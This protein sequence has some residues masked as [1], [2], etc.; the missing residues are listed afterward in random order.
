MRPLSPPNP[1]PR[2]ASAFRRAQT[3][4]DEPFGWHAAATGFRTPH[5][6]SVVRTESVCRRSMRPR[7]RRAPRLT[8]CSSRTQAP[9]FASLVRRCSFDGREGSAVLMRESWERGLTLCGFEVWHLGMWVAQRVY[10]CTCRGEKSLSSSEIVI[11]LP[12]LPRLPRGAHHAHTP[13]LVLHP[14]AASLPRTPAPCVGHNGDRCA[15][16]R[17][18]ASVLHSLR[19][20]TRRA[21]QP[22][23]TIPLRSLSSLGSSSLA[24]PPSALRPNSISRIALISCSRLS[25]SMRLR[26][27]LLDFHGRCTYRRAL[28]GLAHPPGARTLTALKSWA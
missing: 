18:A 21:S 19:Q 15:A 9:S 1:R 17:P 14:R 20:R 27:Q 23:V 3:A 6:W 13:C 2:P 24:A 5:K 28:V 25:M 10:C 7:R 4:A 12:P 8:R 11:R 26:L 22:R 16:S